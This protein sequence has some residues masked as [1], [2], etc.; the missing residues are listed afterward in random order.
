LK[1][2]DATNQH[3]IIYSLVSI[4]SDTYNASE[5]Y[6]PRG[7]KGV[8]KRGVELPV[9]YE[10]DELEVYKDF[11]EFCINSSKSLDIICRHWAMP[12]KGSADKE[13][14]VALDLPS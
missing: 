7:S 1:T 3:D 8:K 11:T 4:A 14:D 10:K 9:N 5:S 2:F 13:R 6:Q 12:V